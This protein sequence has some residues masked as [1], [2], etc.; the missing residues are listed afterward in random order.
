MILLWAALAC[1]G[2]EPQTLA[3]CDRLRDP[4]AR[5]DCRLTQASDLLGNPA[6]FKAATAD[7]DDSS[8]DLLITRLAFQQPTHARW[9][10]QGMR[11]E[12]GLTRCKR[13]LG[14]PHLGASP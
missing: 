5:E 3:D 13:L 10:C 14:R 2:S 8:H 12:E 4:T 9:L 11:T 7:L 6:A 1:S